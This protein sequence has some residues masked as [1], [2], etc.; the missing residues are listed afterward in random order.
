MVAVDGPVPGFETPVGEIHVIGNHAFVYGLRRDGGSVDIDCLVDDFDGITF[1]ADDTFDIVFVFS[2]GFS[3]HASG[4]CHREICRGFFARECEN[5]D[6]AA[7]RPRETRDI[8]VDEWQTYAIAELRDKQL[9]TLEKRGD[10]RTRGDFERFNKESPED[11]CDSERD[12]QA[13]DDFL[14]ARFA[15]EREAFFGNL[16]ERSICGLAGMRIVF[17]RL[18]E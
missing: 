13:L 10:H 17:E 6:I 16:L 9:I 4:V 3:L 7:I 12:E 2:E 18:F 15:R 11:E 8:F 5:N 14:K 1:E